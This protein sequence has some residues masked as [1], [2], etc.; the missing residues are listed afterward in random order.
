[1]KSLYVFKI[2]EASDWL[3]QAESINQSETSKFQ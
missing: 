1:M 3:T 2:F